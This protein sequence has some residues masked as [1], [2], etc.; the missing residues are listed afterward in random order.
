[1]E[2]VDG[3][4]GLI[5]ARNR[6]YLEQG[7]LAVEILGRGSAWL[8]TGTPRALLDA[9]TFVAVVEARQ[10]LKIACVEEVAWRMGYTD[11]HRL[12]VLAR[13]LEKSSYGQYLPAL[14]DGDGSR[15]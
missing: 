2:P 8:V 11:T 9:V 6:G 15:G 10:G 12:A 7:R 13:A 1:V 4:G 3:D 14:L 5:E